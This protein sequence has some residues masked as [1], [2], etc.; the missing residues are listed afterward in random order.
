MTKFFTI[1]TL[2]VT[3]LF[4]GQGK[5]EEGMGKAFKLWGEGNSTEA[6]ALFERIASAEKDNWLP[7]YYVGLVNVTSAFTTQDKEKLSALL[8]KAQDAVDAELAKAPEN[9]ELLVLQAM[10]YTAWIVYDPMTNGQKFG[11]KAMQIY[12][13]A[14]KIAPNNPRVVFCKAEFEI[15][16]AKFWGT[17]TKPMCAEVDRAIGLFATY[18][19][20]TKFGPS[21][22]LDRA[23]Q[24]Q[25]ACKK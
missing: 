14:I 1:I 12:E 21:W 11:A 16:G 3:G 13:Q 22:G 4:F 20:D 9:P 18:K 23:L 19:D 15:G 2:L 7:N 5:Y 6:S 8:D 10:I 17:D 24:T 25:E